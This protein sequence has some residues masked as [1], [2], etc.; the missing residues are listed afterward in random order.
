MTPMRLATVLAAS[1][2]CTGATTAV[3]FPFSTSARDPGVNRWIWY[4]VLG[5]R[6][7]PFSIVY[8]STEHFVTR[9]PEFLV[10]L[11]PPR[12][13][14]ISSYTNARIARRDCPGKEPTTEVWYTVDIA[15]HE[16]EHTQRCILPQASACEYLSAVIK[17][18]G[19]NWAAQELRPINDF[20]AQIKCNTTVSSP[21]PTTLGGQQPT[22]LPSEQLNAAEGGGP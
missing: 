10:V 6:N 9:P 13:D 16:Q 3:D 4:Q 11:P 5:P 22:T 1:I 21:A 15:Q 12:Y 17:L 7:S 18:S 20:M 19:I 8:I 14:V 2:V